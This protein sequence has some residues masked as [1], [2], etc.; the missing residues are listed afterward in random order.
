MLTELKKKTFEISVYREQSSND[1]VRIDV[2]EIG[3]KE[4]IVNRRNFEKK[5]KKF[6]GSRQTKG[7]RKEE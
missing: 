1:F 7:K 3:L 4:D 5:V 6:S 2:V